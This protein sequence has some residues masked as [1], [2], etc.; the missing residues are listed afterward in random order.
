MPS[1]RQGERFGSKNPGC[2]P[3][4]PEIQVPWF[5]IVSFGLALALALAL[6]FYVAHA[7]IKHL[8]S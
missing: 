2:D 5:A 3:E 1:I 7:I 6:F 8:L 4:G